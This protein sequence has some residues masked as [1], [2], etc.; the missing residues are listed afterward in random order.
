MTGID[1]L[2]ILALTQGSSTPRHRA[3]VAD[4]W[5]RVYPF[6][7]ATRRGAARLGAARLGAARRSASRLV[8]LA[9]ARKDGERRMKDDGEA[10]WTRHEYP[11]TKRVATRVHSWDRGNVPHGGSV[12]PRPSPPSLTL[13][14]T[15][16]LPA[17]V[18]RSVY[19]FL[20]CLPP[21]LS[22]PPYSRG[23][24]FSLAS[25]TCFYLPLP[26]APLGLADPLSLPQFLTLGLFVF[27][28]SFP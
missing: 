19:L 23:G 8:P 22:V 10:R 6:T 7:D 11:T 16:L 5:I 17:H 20:S 4:V 24:S 27:L 13:T 26:R 21:S 1:P 28:L 2:S 14:L 12:L 18:S 15:L 3:R 25:S 9:F